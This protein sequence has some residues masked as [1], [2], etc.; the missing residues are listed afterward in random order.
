LIYAILSIPESHY[1]HFQFNDDT[2]GGWL[3]SL[4]YL[5]LIF[6]CW[7]TFA[8]RYA[9]REDHR[10]LPAGFWLALSL[11]VT[12]LGL[13]KQ[14]D[15]QVLLFDIGRAIFTA[16]GIIEYRFVVEGALVVIAAIGVIGLAV[17]LWPRAARASTPERL[18]LIGTAALIGV[19]FVRFASINHV[20]VGETLSQHRPI[21]ALEI[22][23]LAFLSF[24]VWRDG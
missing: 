13:N 11:G 17:Y 7:R 22:L 4:L 15:L 1:W 23:A 12:A 14:L 18:V 5:I 16:E 8:R 6:L 2:R 10:A 24:A 9:A 19:I 20:K 21:L 3:A